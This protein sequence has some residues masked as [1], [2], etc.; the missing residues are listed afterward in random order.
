MCNGA[1]L[2]LGCTKALVIISCMI[3]SMLCQVI[4]VNVRATSADSI[5]ISDLNV[6]DL[7]GNT[8]LQAAL[9]QPVV[10]SSNFE[11]TEIESLSFITIFEF[12][13]ERDVSV[14]IEIHEGLIDAGLAD[15]VKVEWEP[16]VEGNFTIREF[17]IS[18]NWDSPTVLSAIVSKSLTVTKSDFLVAP[19]I[20]PIEDDGMSSANRVGPAQYT[21]MIYMVASD[22]ESKRYAATHDIMEMMDADVHPLVNIIVQTGGSANSTVDET[23]F[24]D[25]TKVQRHEI[26]ENKIETIMEV[27]ERNMGDS[28]TLASFVGWATTEYPAEKYAIIFWDHGNGIR[29][30]GYDDIYS[31]SLTINEI[32]DGTNRAGAKFELIGF[33]GCLMA[34]LEV[35]THLAQRG[36]YLVASQEVEPE[37]GWDYR[38]VLSSFSETQP[39]SID[40][41]QLGTIIANSYMNHSK[42]NANLYEGYDSDR[43]ITLSV[44]DLTKIARVS[45]E[46][47]TF[48]DLLWRYMSELKD[49]QRFAKVIHQT[50]RYGT[51]YAASSGY[52]DLYEMISNAAEAFPGLKVVG[53]VV[54][55]SLEEAVVYYVKGEA[56]PN[57]HGLS[58]FMQLD[59]YEPGQEHLIYLI[60]EW[61]QVIESGSK[62]L[63]TDRE[64]PSG[65]LD[66]SNGK[67]E[68]RIYDSDVSYGTISYFKELEG[69][70]KYYVI[71]YSEISPS[72]FID[73]RG[74]VEYE[75]SDSISLCSG[76]TCVPAFT[77]MDDSGDSKFAYIPIRLE[78]D[79]DDFNERVSLIYE[80]QD[81]D[82]IFLGAWEGFEDETAQRGL[83]PLLT[84]DRIFTISYEF[85]SSVELDNGDDDYLKEI[86][87]E[88]IKVTEDFGPKYAT[89][90][91]EYTFQMSVCDYVENCAYSE[92]FELA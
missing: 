53:D 92:I 86:E 77:Y 55:S 20:S 29:G 3:V 45:K 35:A 13:D 79:E 58:I 65:T 47:E 87:N 84:G 90:D 11:N 57:A 91:A 9:N 82:F 32:K 74:N 34:T 48:G 21:V 38:A 75:L 85:D 80:I 24:V 7:E 40:G 69:S 12:R 42:Q 1:P 56:K 33:D 67:M 17:F 64:A 39:N 19:R 61:L 43:T 23:R 68:G 73:D 76:D 30:F 78:S 36:N 60:P 14:N 63:E 26:I 27:G 18:N 52:S 31:D 88:E 22:L 5:S 51:D 66:Y 8:V 16:P 37:W 28:N 59:E 71:S 10:L 54:K 25:F 2:G 70:S 41:K 44:I 49:A 46:L 81:N 72:S 15:T 6:Y 83:R 4:P 89:Q 62:T 50:E